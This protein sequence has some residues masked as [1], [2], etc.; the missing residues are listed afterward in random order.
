MS[1]IGIVEMM[2]VVMNVEIVHL[3]ERVLIMF[4]I[5]PV[6]HTALRSMNVVMMVVEAVVE[7]VGPVRSA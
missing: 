1:Q 2:V 4:V 7:N 5:L 6:Y 3:M